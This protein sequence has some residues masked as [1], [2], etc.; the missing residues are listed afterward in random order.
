M[1]EKQKREMLKRV[2]TRKLLTSIKRDLRKLHPDA[3]KPKRS[4]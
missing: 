4:K 3:P 1:D 2:P